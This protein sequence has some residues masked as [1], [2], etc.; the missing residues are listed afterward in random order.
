[1]S[2]DPHATIEVRP[3][4][5]GE[6]RV[7][8]FK[9]LDPELLVEFPDESDRGGLVLFQMAAW[10]I[11]DIWIPTSTGGPVAQEHPV[12]LDEQTGYDVVDTLNLAVAH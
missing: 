4:Q 8:W 10:K 6:R 11:P 12:S 5:V 1:M 3:P 2:D 9:N 7:G